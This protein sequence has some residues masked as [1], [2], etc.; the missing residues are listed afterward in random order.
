M[1]PAN[2]TKKYGLQQEH[3]DKQ[4]GRFDRNKAAFYPAMGQSLK[5][6]QA[7]LIQKYPDFVFKNLEHRISMDTSS[8][9]VHPK[10]IEVFEKIMF[11]TSPWPCHEAV[12]RLNGVQG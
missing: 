7:N 11:P 12:P 1:L 8:I 9:I 2:G 3:I 5:P 6:N 10:S 4:M